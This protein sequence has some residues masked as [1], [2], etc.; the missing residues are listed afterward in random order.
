[1]AAVKVVS[2]LVLCMLVV[3][4]MTTTAISC[5]DVDKLLFPCLFYL[6]RGGK[7]PSTCCSGVRALHSRTRT[8][9]DRQTVCKCFKNYFKTIPGFKANL[10]ESL[11]GKCRVRIPYKISFSANCK[12]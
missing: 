10:G 11:P 2:V 6:T 9:S 3:E 8:T 4:P 12:K 1:M 5:V 7:L